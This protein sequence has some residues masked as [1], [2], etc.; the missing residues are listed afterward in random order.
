MSGAAVTAVVVAYNSAAHLPSCISA[1]RAACREH[2]L[3][4]LV[5]DNASPDDTRATL[6]GIGGDVRLVAMGRNAGFAAACNAG[7]A[8]AD[9]EYVCFVNPDARPAPAAIDALVAAERRRSGHLLYSGKVVTPT[10]VVDDGCCR[11]LPSLW[12]YVCFATGLST[13]FPRSRW[14]D[15]GA[16]GSWDREDERVVPAVSGAF[17]LARREAFVSVGGFDARFFMYSEDTDLSAR[18]AAAG[19]PPLFVPEAVACHDGGASSTGGAKATMVLRGKV[20]YLRKHW[21][22]PRRMLGI[23]L[24][25]AGTAIRAVGAR[26]TGRGQKWR[27]VWAQRRAWLHGW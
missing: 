10:G 6:A 23:G 26:A 8:V 17:L 14:F 22:A 15:P 1:I 18:A 16:L 20:T 4:V 12:E 13:A 27:E 24:L 21:S 11:S 19:L 9:S 25:R 5:V 3:S 7:V 2:D